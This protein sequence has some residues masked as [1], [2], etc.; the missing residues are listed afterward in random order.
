VPPAVL[1]G[2]RRARIRKIG[3]RVGRRFRARAR[4]C[5][6][7]CLCVF[8]VPEEISRAC[9]SALFETETLLIYFLFRSR[10][11]GRTRGFGHDVAR[12]GGG[13][14][15]EHGWSSSCEVGLL[16]HYSRCRLQVACFD[17]LSCYIVNLSRCSN[18][19]RCCG[20]MTPIWIWRKPFTFAPD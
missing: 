12:S 15:R 11:F 8:Y 14:A 16:W 20:Y 9:S 13:P 5:V 17:V 7:V 3:A 10:S 19:S 1:V 2:L 4:A 18:I 6:C